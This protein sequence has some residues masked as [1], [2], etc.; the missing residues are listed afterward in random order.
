[1]HSG[2]VIADLEQAI[3]KCLKNHPEGKYIKSNMV[4]LQ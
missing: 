2:H 3:F 1:M 4:K